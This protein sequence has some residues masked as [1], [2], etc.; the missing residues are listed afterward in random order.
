MTNK[1]ILIEW[2]TPKTKYEKS[3]YGTTEVNGDIARVYI[4][5]N[6]SSKELVDTFFHEMA[7]VFF[8]FHK[9]NKHMTDEQEEYLAGK[10]GKLVAG[11]LQ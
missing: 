8:G 1:V 3:K 10:V 7:H 2:R 4:Q 9:K 6:Q 5:Q 11:L